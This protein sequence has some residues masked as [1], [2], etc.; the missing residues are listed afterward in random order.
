M[1]APITT[2]DA[3]IYVMVTMSAVDSTMTDRELAQIGNITRTL[4]IFD[5]FDEERLVRISRENVKYFLVACAFAGAAVLTYA[6]STLVVLCISYVV[7]VIWGLLTRRA[8]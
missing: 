1:S 4:P 6:W 3:L 2:Q 5:D 8:E 7:L